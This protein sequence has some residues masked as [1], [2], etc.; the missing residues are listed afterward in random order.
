MAKLFSDEELGLQTTS[1]N[2]GPVI[3]LGLTFENDEKRRAYF[4]EELRKKLPELKQLEGFPIGEDDDIIA[5]SDP[6][7]Y[8][9]CPNPWLN[10]FINEWEKEKKQLLSR[11]EREELKEV[12]EPY[13][14]GIQQGK[15]SAI[16]NAHSYHTKVPHEVI[17]RYILH[18]TQPGDVVLDS[19]GGSGMTAVAATACGCPDLLTK[20]EITED[21]KENGLG[22]PNWGKRHAICGDLSPLCFHI[23]SNY[24]SAIDASSL[25]KIVLEIVKK[26]EERFGHLYEVNSEF[27]KAHINYF[28]WSEVVS[29]NNCGQELNVHDLSYDYK[30]GTLYDKLLCPKCGMLQKRIDANSIFETNYDSITKE[31]IEELK[32]ECCLIN[33]SPKKG[34]YFSKNIP[35]AELP[36]FQGFIPAYEWSS[37][38]KFGDPKRVGVYKVNQLYYARTQYLLAYLHEIINTEYVGYKKALMFI[39]TSMLPKLTRM[40]RYMP[41]HGSRALVGPMANTLY[42]PPQCVENNPIDQF[43][44][45]AGKV[46]KALRQ[47][48]SGSA[49]QVASATNSSIADGMVDYIFTDPPFGANIMYSE[50]NTVSESWLKVMTNN[51]EE[52]I[53]NKSQ[54]KGIAEYQDIM[55][56]CFREYY[57]VLKPGGWMTVEFSNTSASFWNSLQFSI[58]SAGFMISAITDLNKERGGLHA[59]L[60]PTAVK[61]D[62]AISCYKPTKE[63]SVSLESGRSILLWDFVETHLN[64]IAIYIKKQGKI[65]SISEREP[66]IIYDRI[67]SFYIQNGYSIPMNAQEFQKGLRERFIERDG[68]F[69]TAEQVLKYEDAKAKSD[70]V[71]PLGLFISSE[72]EGIQWLKNKLQYGPKTYQQLQ[73]DWMQDLVAGKKGDM[74]PELQTILDEN[75]I[76][77]EDGAWH[78]PNPEKEADLEALRTKR[79]LKEFNLYV[80]QASKPRVKLKEVR[81]EALRYGFKECY[82]SKDFQTIVLVASRIPE[83]LVMEDEVLLQYYD[84]A[85]SR[86]N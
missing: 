70:G 68:M 27:G 66:R 5:L 10:D 82:R 83:A 6:P 49:I 38:D 45:Q 20:R 13:A 84:I 1:N 44:Y 9:A 28:V 79:L 80:E 48:K 50:L 2:E 22:E 81:L 60:G 75:F 23:A 57:R 34:R 30:S 8:T 4:R 61:Q 41:Q 17:M 15:N 33:I 73:P 14:Y 42:I 18:Y 59:M 46:I 40:N 64:H 24:N 7:Y 32:Y 72:A 21:Y 39:F 47:C 85:A 62:L 3:C 55:T 11:G 53:S 29:C 65:V 12:T 25:E 19:F 86:V 76:Q 37:G 63:F 36:E 74:I 78:I 43:K 26:L 69:F 56:A 58:K 51:H 31:T 16:Y 35:V 54:R 52:A 67:I 77:D 71:V